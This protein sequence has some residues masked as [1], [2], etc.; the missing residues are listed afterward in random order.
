MEDRS[1]WLVGAG[2]SKFWKGRDVEP[3][4]ASALGAQPRSEESP[5]PGTVVETGNG[6][7]LEQ[8]R[9][10]QGARCSG[11]AGPSGDRVPSRAVNEGDPATIS[12]SSP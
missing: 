8:L 6:F 4:S 2:F 10:E 7:L 1:P 12:E 5:S 9:P 11:A 3:T